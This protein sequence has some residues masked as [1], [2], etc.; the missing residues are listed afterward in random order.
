MSK[1]QL[2]TLPGE[3]ILIIRQ[4]IIDHYRQIHYQ[5]V[6]YAYTFMEHNFLPFNQLL[7]TQRKYIVSS[8][9]KLQSN[10]RI[11]RIIFGY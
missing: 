8:R 4:Y 5:R 11:R 9:S 6:Q 1:H 3:I 10:L 2:N 7:R